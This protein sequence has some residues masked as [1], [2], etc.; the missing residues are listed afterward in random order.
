MQKS[1]PTNTKPCTIT[2]GIQ[3]YRPQTVMRFQVLDNNKPDTYFLNHS[4]NIL[5]GHFFG[6]NF[7]GYREFD[8]YMPQSPELALI[9]IFNV[10]NGN[11]KETADKSFEITKWEKKDSVISEITN[12]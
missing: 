8:L 5:N 4:G 1:V 7:D 12:C 11:L 9:N 6:Q 2:V 10:N 3:A